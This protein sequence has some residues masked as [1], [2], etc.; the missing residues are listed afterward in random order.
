MNKV[1]EI[2]EYVDGGP[3]D[4]GILYGFMPYKEEYWEDAPENSWASK[5]LTSKFKQ[6]FKQKFDQIFTG[7]YQ[8]QLVSK[9]EYQRQRDKK[10]KELNKFQL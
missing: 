4:Y 3:N 9:N 8:A 10:E 7:F 2:R 1:I 5:K 6:D